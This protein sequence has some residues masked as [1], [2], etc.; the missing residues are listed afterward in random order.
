MIIVLVAAGVA[1][2]AT[3]ALIHRD[4]PASINGFSWE[5]SVDIYH[6]HWVRRSSYWAPPAGSRN[7]RSTT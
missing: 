4:R 6:E 5:R 2:L 1:I 7:H 3:V